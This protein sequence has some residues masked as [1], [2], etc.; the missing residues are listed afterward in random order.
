MLGKMWEM[1]QTFERG[2][3]KALG[4]DTEEGRGGGAHATCSKYGN[5]MLKKKLE[6]D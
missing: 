5:C 6:L 4:K 2:V 3:N 1:P